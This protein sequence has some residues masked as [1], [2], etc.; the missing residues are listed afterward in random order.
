MTGFGMKDFRIS[1]ETSDPVEI[2]ENIKGIPEMLKTLLD[3]VK[4]SDFD[5]KRYYERNEE[6]LNKSIDLFKMFEDELKDRIE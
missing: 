3:I 2:Y 4:D 6:I 1:Q 5:F